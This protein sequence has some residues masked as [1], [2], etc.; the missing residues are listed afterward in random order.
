MPPQAPPDGGSRNGGPYPHG[1]DRQGPPAADQ[2]RRQRRPRGRDHGDGAPRPPGAWDDGPGDETGS[3][4][5]G[6]PPG[7]G[8]DYLPGGPN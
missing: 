2:E 1:G 3:A 5:L 4:G 6:F 7:G 8:P